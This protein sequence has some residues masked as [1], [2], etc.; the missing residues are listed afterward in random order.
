MSKSPALAL[1]FRHASLSTAGGVIAAVAAATIAGAWFFEYVIGLVPCELCLEQRVPYYLAIPLA[2]VLVFLARDPKRAALSRALLLVIGAI[3][4][5]GAGLGV[6]HSGVEWG[7]WPGPSSCTGARFHGGGSLLSQ[8][9]AMR[10][11]PCDEVQ[12]RF[13][14]LSLAGYNALIAGALAILA[15][16]TAT[17]RAQ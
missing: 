6:Y 9:Q 8:M 7:W 5:Y 14:G 11:V 3:L 12:W 15:L 1:D 4:A 2:L 13:F 17:R 16:F 10:V